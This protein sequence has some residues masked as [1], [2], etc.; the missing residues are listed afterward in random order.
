MSRFVFVSS[1]AYFPLISFAYRYEKR[2]VVINYHG[3]TS[4]LRSSGEIII[5][6][7]EFWKDISTFDDIKNAKQIRQ[8]VFII[9]GDKDVNHPPLDAK[10]V[11]E[12]LSSNDKK[13]KI[14]FGGDHGINDVSRPMREEFLGDIMQWFKRTL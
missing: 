4:L 10:K 13:I 8:S 1:G 12:A 5:V 2:G 9:Q 11:F 14:F 6:G 7:K 3:D